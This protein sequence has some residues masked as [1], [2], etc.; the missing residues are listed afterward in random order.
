MAHDQQAAEKIM[1]TDDTW[2]IKLIG[3][4]VKVT[5]EYI[6]NRL[7]IATIGN[8]AKYRDNP[9]LMEVLLETEELRLFEGA[10]SSFWAGGN[11]ITLW[12]MIM[13]IHMV[14]ITREKC[15]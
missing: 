7:H 3:D 11:L 2:T 4:K 12:L 5:P 6:E 15:S 1:N 8:E 10:T 14:R 13:R 9:D